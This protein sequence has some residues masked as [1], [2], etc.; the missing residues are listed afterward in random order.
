MN[1]APG[2]EKGTWHSRRRSTLPSGYFTEEVQRE[3]AP[4]EPGF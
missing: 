3:L 1:K 2:A 4:S